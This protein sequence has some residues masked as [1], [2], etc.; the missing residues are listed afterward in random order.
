MQRKNP[1]P[2]EGQY[3]AIFAIVILFLFSLPVQAAASYAPPQILSYQG[4]LMDASGNLLGGTGTNYFFRFSIWDTATPGTGSRVWPAS[5]PASVN[6]MVAQGVFSVNIGDTAAGYPDALDLNPA[7]YAQL[8][9]QV[10][11][12]SNNVTFETLAPRAR[13]TSALFANTAGAVIGTSP[14]A[15]GT[16][17][18]STGSIV[19]V[20]GGITADAAT[21]TT[22]HATTATIDSLSLGTL[23]GILKATAG[24]VSSAFVNLATDVTGVLGIANGGTGT[25]TAPVANRLLLSDASGNWEYVATS[26][27]GIVSAA[28]PTWGSITGSLGSQSDLSTA[29]ASK[30]DISALTGKNISLFTNDAGYSLASAFGPSFYAYLHG[31]T[32]DALAEGS[33]NLYFTSNR[34]ASILAGTTTDTLTEGASHLYFTNGRADARAIAVLA[35]TTSLPNISSLSGLS[36]P[37]AQ[38]TG[39]PVTEN[40]LTF[41]YP[42]ARTTNTISLAFGTTTANSWR[43]AQQFTD[44]ATT[45]SLAIGSLSGVLKAASGNVTGGAT[46]NDLPEGGANQYFTPARVASVIAGTTTDALVEGLSNLYF[47]TLRAD[48]R[49]VAVL[50]ATSSL[51]NLTTLSGLSLPYSQLTGAPATESPLIFS[52]PFTRSTNTIA[53]AFGTTTANTWGAAQQFMN[54][55]TTTSLA[56]GSFSGVLKATGGV[57]ASGAT[58]NDLPEGGANQYFTPTRAITALTGQNVSLFANDANYALASAFGANFYTLFHATTTNAL[59]EG[60]SNLYFTSARASSTAVAVLAATSSLPNLTTLSGLSLPYA[61]LTGVPAFENPLTFNYPFTRSTNTISLAFGTTTA[62]AWS[63]LQQLNG[64]ASTTNI[65][66]SGNALITGNLSVGTNA[67]SGKLTVL[68]NASNGPVNIDLVNNATHGLGNEVRIRMQTYTGQGDPSNASYIS[69][70]DNNAGSGANDMIFGVWGGGIA[71]LSEVMRLKGSGN[72]GIGTTNPLSKLEVEGTASVLN[73]NATSTTATS[74]FSGGVALATSAGNVGI[75]TANPTGLLTAF[76]NVQNG[77]I[78]IDLINNAFTGTGNEVRLR[79]QSYTGL[80]DPSNGAYITNLETNS[81]SGFNVLAFGN[82]GGEQMRIQQDGNIGIGTTSPQSRL[83]VDDSGNATTTPLLISN[84]NFG[85]SSASVGIAFRTDDAKHKTG[86]T[87]ASISSIL[88]QNYNGGKGDLVFSTLNVGTVAEAMRIL[89]T[90]SVGIGTT[91]PSNLV[92]IDSLSTTG[93]RLNIWNG[94]TG[95]HGWSFLSSGSAS[96]IG[97][98]KF[99]LADASNG[100]AA[101]LV[102]DSVGNIGI[103]TSSPAAAFVVNASAGVNLMQVATSTNQGIFS[104]GSG[105]S[106]GIGTSSPRTSSLLDLEQT[107][108][109]LGPILTIENDSTGSSARPT[110]SLR[111][112]TKGTGVIDDYFQIRMPQ[113]TSKTQIVGRNATDLELTTDVG[114]N[115]FVSNASVGLGTTT[116]A[117]KLEVYNGNIRIDSDSARLVINNP[118]LNTA[119][120][121]GVKFTNNALAVFEGDDQQAQTYAY[122][123]NFTA[124]RTNASTLRV[125]GPSANTFGNYIALTHTGDLGYGK[126][127]TDTGSI[128]LS[129]AS[130]LVGVGTT[131]PGANLVVNG[132]TGQNLLQVATSTNQSVFVIGSSG[133]VGIGTSTPQRHLDIANSDGLSQIMLEDVRATTGANLHYGGIRFSNGDFFINSMSDALVATQRFMIAST[134][135]AI[136]INTQSS[137]DMVAIKGNGNNNLLETYD[138][139]GTSKLVIQ[140]SGLIGVGTSSPFANVSVQNGTNDAS[141][142]TFS[143]TTW[144]EFGTGLNRISGITF[145]QG[146]SFRITSGTSYVTQFPGGGVFIIDGTTG[147]TKIGSVIG[148]TWAKLTV[149]DNTTAAL[150][151][152]HYYGTAGTAD[153][154]ITFLSGTN[155]GSITVDDTK[156]GAMYFSAGDASTLANREANA[157]L[158]LLQ[159]GN[160]GV[161]STSPWRTFG[162][163]GTVSFSGLTSV[164]ANQSAYICLSSTNEVVKDSTTCLASSRRFKQDIAPIGASSALAEVLALQPV[165]YK[166]TPEYNGA[167]QSDPNFNGEFVGFIAEDVAKVDPRLVTVDA[168]GTTPDAPHAVR[169]ENITAILA[170]AVQ[171]IAGVSG[172]FRSALVAWLA[173][174]GN[175]IG[176][177]VAAAIHAKSVSTDNLCVG[178]VCVTQEQF[179]R[180]VQTAGGSPSPAVSTPPVE[181]IPDDMATTT[182]PVASAPSDATTTDATSTP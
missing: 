125:H 133:S 42:L 127:F 14:S 70:L 144:A 45:T 24:V 131:T 152:M 46:T 147:N 2:Q 64:G 40:P 120:R 171:Q 6:A 142:G 180:M 122:Y 21:S 57:V 34:V 160:F 117:N 9:L 12:S 112:D 129:P 56:I 114:R 29:L 110:I 23:S 156:S 167:L 104:I 47:T 27:L 98:G 136:G 22:L 177:L 173:D 48:A 95:A 52:Y 179:L 5:S 67:P 15:F 128:A 175:G 20:A 113:G 44:G 178:T 103:G 74:T 81:A 60:A 94:T 54:G 83:E 71:G 68:G 135:G 140:N 87:T 10:E 92:D 53:L 163:A 35:A 145:D 169:Y 76:S 80:G 28:S 102:V 36:L 170:G 149:S 134:T 153:S 25:S 61:Q 93:T 75:G 79:F 116:P 162:V 39:T 91:T 111:G 19:T 41:S 50:A 33:S 176:D 32:T 182:E 73:L 100:N 13:L 139:S 3:A 82:R 1:P 132:T 97:A 63:S 37:Y 130:G 85:T 148:D 174:T 49:A 172:E 7:N 165:S 8:Y 72:V 4:R 66:A 77:P 115:I 58:T 146:G 150:L 99:A 16:T 121:V 109:F 155:K 158:A 166:Y 18:P 154:G 88:Q 105:G 38:L 107:G 43:A 181:T 51:P 124:A 89:S 138:S 11:V 164:S 59:A 55:A 161:A 86:T 137:D 141:I 31:T 17:S 101:R 118:T 69:A 157:K 78:N 143:T 96:P 119:A 84:F 168:T 90:G 123:S 62:N 159:T 65:S 126:I 106:V 30:L 108:N 151:S 26:S